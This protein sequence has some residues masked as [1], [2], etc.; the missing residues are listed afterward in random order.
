MTR[1]H[2]FI[3]MSIHAGLKASAAKAINSLLSSQQIGSYEQRLF[4]LR[5]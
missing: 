3:T 2:L 5:R 1:S 4:S